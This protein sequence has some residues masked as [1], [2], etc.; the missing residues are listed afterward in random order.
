M[1]KLIL[2]LNLFPQVSLF[3]T[4]HLYQLSLFSEKWTFKCHFAYKIVFVYM[5]TVC[6]YKQTA[7]V[8]PDKMSHNVA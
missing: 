6:V 2:I 3:V 1:E 5:K 4:V 8:D 7:R